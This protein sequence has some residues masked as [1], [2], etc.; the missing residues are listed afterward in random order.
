MTPSPILPQFLTPVMH[1]QCEGFCTTAE[2]PVGLWWC[3]IAQ[4]VCL[5]GCYRQK[6]EK[7]F[8]PPT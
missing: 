3:L 6:K 7:Q 1:F 2:N 4:K 5:G 8:N